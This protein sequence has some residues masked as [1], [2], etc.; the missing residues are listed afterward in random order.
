MLTE[1]IKTIQAI[2]PKTTNGG[3][4]ADYVSLKNA[5]KVRIIVELTQAVGH[6]TLITPKQATAVDGTGVKALTNNC[7]ILANED[8]AS[9]DTLARQTDAKN[10]TVTA[11]VKNKQIVFEIN[12]ADSF[13]TANDF[14]CLGLAIA[15]SSQATNIASATYELYMKYK[16]DVP[17]AAITD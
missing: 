5:H 3:I 14:D 11:D 17:P 15:D 9:T 16:E 7:V 10:Y 6:A 12:P 13:D 1:I 8:T 2:N 4:T